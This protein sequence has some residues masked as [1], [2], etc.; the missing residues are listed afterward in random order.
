MAEEKQTPR[1]EIEPEQDAVYLVATDDHVCSGIAL[2]WDELDVVITV[3]TETRRAFREDGELLHSALRWK[4]SH[5][6]RNCR[7]D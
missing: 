6:A 7:Y 3:L 5:L 2:T 1:L 4:P